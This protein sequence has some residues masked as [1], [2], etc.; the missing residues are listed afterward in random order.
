MAQETTIPTICGDIGV[1]QP[2]K[3]NCKSLFKIFMSYVY[4][5]K[6]FIICSEIFIIYSEIFIISL[7]VP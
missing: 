1:C 2:M 7:L 5:L 3:N 6:F 4:A